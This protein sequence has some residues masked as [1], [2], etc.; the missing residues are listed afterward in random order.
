MNRSWDCSIDYLRTKDN[1][2]EYYSAKLF[3]QKERREAILT[4][5]ITVFIIT[6]FIIYK[7]FIN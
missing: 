6:V 2:K 1:N 7:L 4:S 5:T 3:M